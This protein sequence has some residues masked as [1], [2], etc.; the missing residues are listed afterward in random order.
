M[1]DLYHGDCLE[2]MKGIPDGSIDM[3]L[4]DLPYGTTACEWDRLLPF[5][6]LWVQYRRI[7]KPA[8]A[9]VLFGSEPFSTRL[10]S[11][12]LDWYKYDWIWTKRKPTGFAQAKNKPLKDYEN[13]MVFSSGTTVHAGQSANRMTYNPQGLQDCNIVQSNKN[14][15]GTIAGNR[16]SH[17]EYY[18]QTKTGYPR[19][20]LYGYKLDDK[21]VHPTQK[22]VTL[23][24]YLVK[25]YTNP[26]DVV[27]DNCMGSGSTGVACINTSRNFIG[28]ELDPGYFEIAQKRIDD[29]MAEQRAG[30]AREG[31]GR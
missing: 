15:F 13:I 3:I 19:M 4:C 30:D 18:T 22:P 16:P 21:A 23:L 2:L 7:I 20:V 9:I 12:A 27:L 8:G 1:I 11:S 17:K 6:E 26:G 10:R 24:E 14:K 5:G 25:T 29:A 28:M 31:D